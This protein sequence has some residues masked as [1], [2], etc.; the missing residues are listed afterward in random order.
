M[1]SVSDYIDLLAYLKQPQT[2]V[3]TPWMLLSNMGLGEPSQDPYWPAPQTAKH[4]EHLARRLG[5]KQLIL[6]LATGV[7]MAMSLWDSCVA[8]IPNFDADLALAPAQAALFAERWAL[9]DAE[10]EDT[11][12]TRANRAADALRDAVLP[13]LQTDWRGF[14]ETTTPETAAYMVARAAANAAGCTVP[15]RYYGSIAD[16]FLTALR[17]GF[18]RRGRHRF[19]AFWWARCRSRIAF[20]NA[21]KADFE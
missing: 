8:E 13:N 2:V 12:A 4:M 20:F 3:I 16:E 14:P 10:P 19:L 6:C 21:A 1:L 17:I 15:Q 7:S 18:G 5:D 11:W 9:G